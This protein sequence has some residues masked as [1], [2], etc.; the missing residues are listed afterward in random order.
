M[1]ILRQ[2]HITLAV[3]STINL[4][5]HHKCHTCTFTKQKNVKKSI[6]IEYHCIFSTGWITGTKE[7]E[8]TKELHK[9]SNGLW[10][11]VLYGTSY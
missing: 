8:T 9:Q 3:K 6:L 2:L 10:P 1:D 7:Y 5:D 4:V 11:V